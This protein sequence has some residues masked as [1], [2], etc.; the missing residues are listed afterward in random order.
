MFIYET[1]VLL[2]QSVDESVRQKLIETFKNVVESE[3]GE[4]LIIDE[5][6]QKRLAEATSKG[7]TSGFYTYFMYK[8]PGTVNKEIGRRFK[9]DENVIKFINLRLG[10]ES[11][12]EEITKAYK[13]PYASNSAHRP[14][15]EDA[16][17]NE[18]EKRLFARKKSCWFTANKTSPDWKNPMT[19]RWL[20]NDFGKISPSRVTG[21]SSKSQRAANRA[22]KRGRC[23]GLISHVNNH[24]ALS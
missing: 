22:I 16:I 11:K 5:W 1:C 8:A 9:I 19:Y 6:G 13:T 2:N 7:E 14:S 3:K 20:V 21:L 24:I 12:Q 10:D 23:I 17:S 18:K 15:E 4:V